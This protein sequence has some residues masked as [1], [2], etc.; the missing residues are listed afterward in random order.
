MRNRRTAAPRAN[1]PRVP[2]ANFRE[3][4]DT[5]ETHR[6]SLMARHTALGEIA[7]RHPSYKAALR[8]LNDT[9]R[10]TRLAKRLAVLQAAAFLIE[11]QEKLAVAG[12]GR[13]R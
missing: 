2:R 13:M 1:A 6:T 4:Y 12:S 7:R 11:V 9:F 3:R 8:L 10:R 5:M